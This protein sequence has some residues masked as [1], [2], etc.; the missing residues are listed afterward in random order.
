MKTKSLSGL[1]VVDETEGKV[2]AVFATLNVIDHDGDVTLPGAFTNGQKV[3]ISAYNHASWG[4]HPP[5]GKGTIREE[6]DEA[7]LDGEFFLST[8]AGRETFEVVKGLEDLGEWSYGFDVLESEPGRMGDEDVQFLRKLK[9]HEV[10]PVIL[11]AGLGTRTL[12]AKARGLKLT[13]HAEAVLTDLKGLVERAEEVKALRTEQ[14]K[15]LGAESSALLADVHAHAQ[16][17][18][19]VLTTEPE[20]ANAAELA[21][22]E[23]ARFIGL[24][25]L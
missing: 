7:I 23:K 19:E 12:A 3:R 11:G 18:E 20:Q 10:S 1:K 2:Q 24:T 21:A 9:V 8:T 16:R 14:G 6:G 13:D 17:L 5:V 4:D 25:A 15:K 22:R